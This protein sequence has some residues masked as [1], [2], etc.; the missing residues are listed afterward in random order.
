M[1][2]LKIQSSTPHEAIPIFNPPTPTSM[3]SNAAVARTPGRA[4][5]SR[6]IATGTWGFLR[7][8][9]VATAAAPGTEQMTAHQ[10]SVAFM[11]L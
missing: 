10:R 2:L 11:H 1:D 4:I 9:D 8:R 5:A 3:A 6:S 7:E